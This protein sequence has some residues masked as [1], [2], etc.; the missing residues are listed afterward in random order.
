MNWRAAA[1]PDTSLNAGR[2]RRV[3]ISLIGDWSPTPWPTLDIRW[4]RSLKSGD[5]TVSK[6]KDTG[7]L[8][9]VGTVSEQLV[10]EIGDPQAYHLPDVTCDFSAAQIKQAGKDLVTVS[11]A[12]GYAPSNTYKTCL[13]FQDG[14]RIGHLFG[15]YGDDAEEKGRIFAEAAFTR[16]RRILNSM[17][18]PDYYRHID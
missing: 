17:G 10:Y 7:G 15:F 12:K 4:P 14:W 6:P 16:A 11:G 9:T 18:A 1:L 3:E 5:F 13:T 8:V 2:R